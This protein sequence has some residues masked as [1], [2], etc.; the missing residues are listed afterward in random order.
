MAKEY[1]W[2][3][4]TGYQSTTTLS[5][6]VTPNDTSWHNTSELSGTQTFQYWWRDANV[7]SGGGYS[8]A[9]SSRVVA[10]ITNTWTAS[11]DSRNNVTIRV[12]TVLNSL[13]RDDLRGSNVDS[14]GRVIQFY[15]TAGQIASQFTDS[16]LGSAHTISGRVDFGTETFTL[17][18]G[19]SATKQSILVRNETIGYASYDIIGIG[20][21]FMNI[22]PKDYRPGMILDAN[23]VWQSHNRT[24]GAANIRT[25]SAWQEMRT[26]GAPTAKGN[27]P[28][29]Y[30]DGD[31]FNQR[32]IGR[33]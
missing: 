17:P 24:A 18:P 11:I 30:H 10:S 25:S 6:G 33:E 2:R 4:N 5:Y 27:P 19:Q 20:L 32:L 28:S 7:A 12:G 31:W 23:G 16:Q 21:E 22:L 26:E 9:N 14:P 29:I 15:N 3:A 13:V 8:D 1:R